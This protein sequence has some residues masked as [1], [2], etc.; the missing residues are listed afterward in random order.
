M[1]KGY[2]GLM[3]Q[4]LSDPTYIVDIIK[5]RTADIVDMAK[6]VKIRVKTWSQV[7]HFCWRTYPRFTN[8]KVW[9]NYFLKL[10]S[11]SKDKNFTDT[12]LYK[13][14]SSSF[15]GVITRFKSQIHCITEYRQHRHVRWAG[16]G[17][18]FKYERGTD[19]CR[20]FWIEPLK[21]NDLGVAQAFFYP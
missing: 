5:R 10:L 13:W 1:D 6:H 20:N 21:E 19:A 7:F 3:R 18:N 2:D 8:N 4:I 17:G 15:V 16:G 11:F 9:S 12:G 14:H